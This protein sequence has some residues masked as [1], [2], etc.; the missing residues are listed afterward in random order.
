MDDKSQLESEVNFVDRL[1]TIVSFLMTIS[2]ASWWV[3]GY[4]GEHFS[5]AVSFLIKDGHCDPVVNGF[6]NHCFGDFV[7][8]MNEAQKGLFFIANSAPANLIYDFIDYLVGDQPV[9]RSVT[10]GYLV[11]MLVGLSYPVIWS[12]LHTRTPFYKCLILCG[13]LTIP[14]LAVLDRG[15]NF[16]LAIP[17]LLAFAILF[18][19][20]KDKKATG[21]LIIASI[22][23][24]HLLVLLV[25]FLINQKIWHFARGACYGL[26][27]HLSASLVY[28]PNPLKALETHWHQLSAYGTYVSLDNPIVA[29]I[30]IAKGFNTLFKS[31]HIFSSS[32][33]IS[34]IQKDPTKVGLGVFCISTLLMWKDREHLT[35]T[36]QLT[37]L[38]P[39]S[40]MFPGT[41]F[42]PYLAF[43][44]VI[45][46]I[47]LMSKAISVSVSEDSRSL[48]RLDKYV[49]ISLLFAISLSLCPLILPNSSVGGRQLTTIS[50][51]PL[52]WIQFIASCFVRSSLRRKLSRIEVC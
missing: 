15:N 39:L 3:S 44:L 47:Q 46:P 26:A 2:V 30:S 32:E 16:G 28:Q 35:K 7:S 31:M 36:E 19:Q 25:I 49:D 11:L 52:V 27:L 41:T 21:F 18:I 38:L 43:V 22:F 45:V 51:I 33:L 1:L 40:V 13:P 48:L 24:P 8:P 5:E 37:I 17:F 34:V 10:I 20:G 29:N 14:G 9:P 12:S 42:L 23:K 6:G 4:F 50:L